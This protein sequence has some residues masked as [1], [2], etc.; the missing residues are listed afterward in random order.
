MIT[1]PCGLTY[2]QLQALTDEELMAHA[3]E[4][5][6]DALA[7]IVSRY[8]RLVWSVAAKIVHDPG[9][10]EDV[11]QTVF[12]DLFQKVALFDASRGTLKG[13]LMQF[14]YSRSINRRYHLQRRQFYNQA[15]LEEIDIAQSASSAGATLGLAK[16]EIVSLMHEVMTSLPE[17][18]RTAIELIH[19]E[20][21]TFEEMTTRTG[22]TIDAA[23]HQYYRGMAKLKQ[24]ITTTTK[25]KKVSSELRSITSLEVSHARPQS[26]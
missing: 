14:T 1:E 8:Q 18:Q 9:E 24:Y 2:R 3:R 22:Q 20:G 21:L 6:H 25:E 5:H 4:G 15:E 13:W 7:V 11:V 26:I 16:G 19:T 23:K 12:V 17:A 10:A